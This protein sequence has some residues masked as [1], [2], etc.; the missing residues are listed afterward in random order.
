[1]AAVAALEYQAPTITLPS[2]VLA[3]VKKGGGAS[4]V[5][6]LQASVALANM[7]AKLSSLTQKATAK[8]GEMNSNVRATVRDL[9]N[10]ALTVVL[11][12]GAGAALG[13]YGYG[14]MRTYFGA[15]SYA[16][17]IIGPAIGVV[18]GYIGAQVKDKPGKPMASVR[19]AAVGFGG[20][21]ALTS[22][23]RTYQTFLA[24]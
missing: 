3:A 12:G 2:D 23:T 21:I 4:A 20:G 11:S 14:Y 7:R 8:I 19:A 17:D 10:Q 24:A 6:S 18:I 5:Q 1:M 22:L 9:P 15:T 13:W 16:P